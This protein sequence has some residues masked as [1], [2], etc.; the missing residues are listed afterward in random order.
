MI[1]SIVIYSQERFFQQKPASG[2]ALKGAGGSGPAGREG[3]G[4]PG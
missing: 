2:Q 3:C 4:L 1:I